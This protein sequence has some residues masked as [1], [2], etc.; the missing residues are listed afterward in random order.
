MAVGIEPEAMP[1]A[2]LLREVLFGHAWYSNWTWWI[3]QAT[4]AKPHWAGFF[5]SGQSG[6]AISPWSEACT[7]YVRRVTHDEIADAVG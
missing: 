2:R 5:V 6:Q 3:I 1:E 7:G 4:S